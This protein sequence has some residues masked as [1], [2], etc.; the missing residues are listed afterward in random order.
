MTIRALGSRVTLLFPTD[1]SNVEV[2]DEIGSC[3]TTSRG[4][5]AIE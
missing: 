4:Y 1:G 2:A 5:A 3:T